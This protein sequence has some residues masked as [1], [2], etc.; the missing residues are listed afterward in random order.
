MFGGAL[1]HP[2]RCTGW[3]QLGNRV[4]LSDC[5]ERR[6]RDLLMSSIAPVW[7]MNQ[8]WL[9]FGGGA[10]LVAF[11]LIYGIT[12]SALY[13]PVFTFIFGLIF[14]GVTFEFRADA[15]RKEPWDKSFLAV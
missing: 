9:V 6:K 8:T 2:L 7:D 14:R 15:T 11:P 10:L 4:D 3:V 1:H 5:P 13:I 12:F